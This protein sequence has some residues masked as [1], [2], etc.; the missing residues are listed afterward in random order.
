[1]TRDV[2]TLRAEQTIAEAVERAGAS[3]FSRMPVLDAS[4]AVVGMVSLAQLRDATARTSS[5]ATLMQ[6][7]HAIH[8][9]EPLLRA[10]VRMNDL[11]V[12]QLLVVDSE[13]QPRL[14]GLVAM[15]DLVRAHA[16]AAPTG[17]D[18][19]S[20]RPKTVPELVAGSLMVPA[21]I[22]AGETKVQ[23][24]IA[25]LREGAKAF[26]IRDGPRQV[27]VVLPEQLHDFA[28]DEDFQK[29]LIAADFRRPAAT[30]NEGAGVDDLVRGLDGMEAAVVIDDDT[31]SALGVVTK[32]ALARALLDRYRARPSLLP[33]RPP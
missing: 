11:G 14:V 13:A 31:G 5:V 23:E 25:K 27:G 32:N 26:V 24:L 10:V 12:R 3:T 17:A 33:R 15:S 18:A 2:V 19:T 8:G 29:M 7:G 28:S 30:V 1:M 16:R 4:G 20:Q 9:D 6:P 21:T 22:V